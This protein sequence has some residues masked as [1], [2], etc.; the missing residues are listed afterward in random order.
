MRVQNAALEEISGNVSALAQQIKGFIAENRQTLKPTLD[1]LNGVLTII[2]NR[3][4]QVQQSIKGLSTYAMS[5]G[6]SLASGPFFKS[7]LA[8]LVPGQFAQP[9]IDAA[10]SD[11]GLDPNVLSPTQ[12]TDPQTGQPG[13]PAP[14]DPAEPGLQCLP[15]TLSSA[16]VHRGT[17][18]GGRRS[19]GGWFLHQEDGRGGQGAEGP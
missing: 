13:T 5:L 8:N 9:F 4:T 17:P 2:D 15:G 11:L 18:S 16:R 14:E 3:K 6:E 12:R 1:R 7:Y 19:R 10:F